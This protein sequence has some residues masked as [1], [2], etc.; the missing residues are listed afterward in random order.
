[1]GHTMKLEELNSYTKKSTKTQKKETKK[2]KRK[3]CTANNYIQ[4][5]EA[6]NKSIQAVQLIYCEAADTVSRSL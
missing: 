2:N 4:L 6:M 1:M 5:S 3:L